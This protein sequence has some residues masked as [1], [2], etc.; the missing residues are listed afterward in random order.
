MALGQTSAKA[1]GWAPAK[2]VLKNKART[3]G[4]GVKGATTEQVLDDRGLQ[5]LEKSCLPPRKMGTTEYVQQGDYSTTEE[6]SVCF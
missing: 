4:E 3:R 5:I 1:L 2:C 6:F